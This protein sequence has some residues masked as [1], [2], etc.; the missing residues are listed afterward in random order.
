M[1]RAETLSV[2]ENWSHQAVGCTLETDSMQRHRP[3]IPPR[4]LVLRLAQ[5]AEY[6]F[7][8]SVESIPKPGYERAIRTMP[9]GEPCYFQGFSLSGIT[10]GVGPVAIFGPNPT[11]PS[12]LEDEWWRQTPFC[13]LIT[14]A[15]GRQLQASV[16]G[17]AVNNGALELGRTLNG[18]LYDPPATASSTQ[19]TGKLAVALA[20]H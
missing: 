19:L 6:D 20:G 7:P 11:V 18:E 5:N 1:Q 12:R 9:F 3:V 2:L 16:A 10:D 14:G 13:I 15:S 4:D 17:V 8:F